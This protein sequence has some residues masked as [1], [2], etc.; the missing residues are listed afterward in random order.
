[1]VT[2]KQLSDLQPFAHLAVAFDAENEP[3]KTANKMA[4]RINGIALA[5]VSTGDS[6]GTLTCS[7]DLL[8][9]KSGPRLVRGPERLSFNN[10]L[11][12][13]DSVLANANL[14]MRIATS[15]EIEKIYKALG[16]CKAAFHKSIEGVQSNLRETENWN[17]SRRIESLDDVAN[18]ASHPVVC[19][20]APGYFRKHD[21]N[22]PALLFGI[23]SKE[24]SH[25]AN[26]EEA[27]TMQFEEGVVHITNS[28]LEKADLRIRDS[29]LVDEYWLNHDLS[30]LLTEFVK[31]HKNLPKP[32]N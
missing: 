22:R 14:L 24:K 19:Y 1:M 11:R 21:P 15:D 23:I 32:N 13:N 3:F 31:A 18:F 25:L 9:S 7:L 10:S 30:D 8:I 12:I 20:S 26:E 17:E 5:I 27:Y 4:Y 2:I 29:K 16:S 6:D 28:V